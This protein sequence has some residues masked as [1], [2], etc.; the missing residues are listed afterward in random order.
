MNNKDIIDLIYTIKERP[1]M[2]IGQNSISVLRGFLDGWL[3]ANSNELLSN[4]TILEDF[5]KWLQNVYKMDNKATW[6]RIILC[7]SQDESK[8]LESFFNLFDV[9]IVK[10]K[11]NY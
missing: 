9:F 5:E 8:A 11:K 3:Y 6:N 4:C 10:Y 1:A 2:Y 7:Y